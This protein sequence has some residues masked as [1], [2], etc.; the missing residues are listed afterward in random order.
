MDMQTYRHT[1]IEATMDT[2]HRTKE[3]KTKGI[4][5]CYMDTIPCAK[6]KHRN[7]VGIIF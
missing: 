5:I 3:N 1:E 7:F 4:K 6:V 2:R